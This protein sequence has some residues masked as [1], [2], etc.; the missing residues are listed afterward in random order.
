MTTVSPPAVLKPPTGPEVRPSTD[1]LTSL[2]ETS[3]E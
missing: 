2:K 1:G 3:L